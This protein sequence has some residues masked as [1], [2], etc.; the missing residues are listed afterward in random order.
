MTGVLRIIRWT[1]LGLIVLLILAV[2]VREWGFGGNIAL[3]PSSGGGAASDTAAVPA[4]IA[5]GGP[6][7]LTDD[8]GRAVTDAGYRGRWM[9]V[10]FG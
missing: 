8:K 7:Q 5:I 9:L 1:A 6:F 3:A 2:T 4:G 10:F